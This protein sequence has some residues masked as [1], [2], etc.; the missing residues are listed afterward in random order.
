MLPPDARLLTVA[1]V[2]AV[3]AVGLMSGEQGGQLCAVWAI[4]VLQVSAEMAG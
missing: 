1:A 2:T 3:A 4:P